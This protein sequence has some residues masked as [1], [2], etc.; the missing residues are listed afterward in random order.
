MGVGSRVVHE[1]IDLIGRLLQ[2]V[3]VL[4]ELLFLLDLA[5]WL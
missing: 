2:V 5:E 1:R 4:V 3:L